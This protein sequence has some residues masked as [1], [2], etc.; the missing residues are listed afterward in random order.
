MNQITVTSGITSLTAE[1]FIFR[2]INFLQYAFVESGGSSKYSYGTAGNNRYAFLLDFKHTSISSSET[3]SFTEL[4]ERCTRDNGAVISREYLFSKFFVLKLP[5]DYGQQAMTAGYS[6]FVPSVFVSTDDGNVK[7]PSRYIGIL[8]HISSN[9]AY[10]IIDKS[11]DIISGK[12]SITCP[13]IYINFKNALEENTYRINDD[14]YTDRFDYALSSEAF[15]ATMDN[16]ITTNL[17]VPFGNMDL[18]NS[19]TI[20]RQMQSV[21][22]TSGSTDYD[23]YHQIFLRNY[24]GT[25][26]PHKY[27][28]R[29]YSGTVPVLNAPNIYGIT[30][31]TAEGY[32][33]YGPGGTDN[34]GGSHIYTLN[35]VDFAERIAADDKFNLVTTSLSTRV[36]VRY[37]WDFEIYDIGSGRLLTLGKDY[38]YDY[39]MS[40]YRSMT[41]IDTISLLQN[42]SDFISSSD[43]FEIIPYYNRMRR[44]KMCFTAKANVSL[45]SLITTYMHDKRIYR[46]E[47]ILS[48]DNVAVYEDGYAIEKPISGKKSTV[49]GKTYSIVVT[50]DIETAFAKTPDTSANLSTAITDLLDSSDDDSGMSKILEPLINRSINQANYTNPFM[51]RR[52]EDDGKSIVWKIGDF[53]A[54]SNYFRTYRLYKDD[55]MNINAYMTQS[56]GSDA[57]SAYSGSI[58][59]IQASPQLSKHLSSDGSVI[60]KKKYGN[61]NVVTVDSDKTTTYIDEVSGSTASD[62]ITALRDEYLAEYQ[63]IQDAVESMTTAIRK[64]IAKSFVEGSTLASSATSAGGWGGYFTNLTSIG[65]RR[66]DYIILTI[67]D[68]TDAYDKII[69]NITQLGSQYDIFVQRSTIYDGKSIFV[70][71]PFWGFTSA[72][73]SSVDPSDNFDVNVKNITIIPKNKSGETIAVTIYIAGEYSKAIAA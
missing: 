53:K 28:T 67:N 36:T 34:Y 33:T 23:Y 20:N 73:D 54:T 40:E 8:K 17:I 61:V 62:R 19:G 3:E 18:L 31:L 44:V 48:D 24:G 9:A 37:P 39:N 22:G 32:V 26:Y 46:W 72:I 30:T 6:D 15:D 63:A 58:S 21:D 50:D 57:E 45:S 49:S 51:L 13:L 27:I 29:A 71:L 10:L 60:N 38:T 42:K 43:T 35:T 12:D 68:T 4:N 56:F 16:Y 41:M 14:V 25:T 59:H 55:T 11:W 66:C 70:I 52:S 47:I 2:T 5:A 7:I 65:I 1:N 64:N 69:L